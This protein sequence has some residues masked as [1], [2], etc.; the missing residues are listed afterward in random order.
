MKSVALLLMRRSWVNMERSGSTSEIHVQCGTLWSLV[1]CWIRYNDLCC[2][3]C[4]ISVYQSF[5]YFRGLYVSSEKEKKNKPGTH[6]IKYHFCPMT[7]SCV[8][9]QYVLG[10]LGDSRYFLFRML[11]S[12][13]MN[14][15][16]F[17]SGFP[18][19][20]QCSIGII[21]FRGFAS[22]SMVN[23]VVLWYKS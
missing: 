20:Y 19:V 2:K 10:S 5:M 9:S 1:N 12:Y 11:L 3:L 8:V 6:H 14:K 21:F 18:K 16:Y 23:V 7:P 4:N 17:G 22:F 15:V 13:D